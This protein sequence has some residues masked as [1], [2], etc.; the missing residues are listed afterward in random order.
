MMNK[1]VKATYANGFE[2]EGKVFDM[3]PDGRYIHIE[4]KVD[5]YVADLQKDKVEV[6]E[7]EKKVDAIA[8]VKEEKKS[9]LGKVSTPIKEAKENLL[10]AIRYEEETVE[11]AV[12]IY[13]WL[14]S[15]DD[16][17][18]FDVEIN[19]YSE[20]SYQE[21]WTTNEFTKPL[22]EE[23]D[24]M[25]RAKAVLR[26]VKGWFEYSEDVNVVDKIEVYRC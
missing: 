25:K 4:N 2:V 21:G 3:S 14:D 18:G 15:H 7:K 22:Y 26:L 6:I 9:A 24:A 5:Y 13:D 12:K 8:V 10:K 20:G 1:Q 11:V 23:K 17:E 16:S 19:W